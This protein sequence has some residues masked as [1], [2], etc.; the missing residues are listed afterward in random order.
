MLV[1]GVDLPG[2]SAR[3]RRCGRRAA[4]LLLPRVR[5]G[6]G[7]RRRGG[8]DRG[9]RQGTDLVAARP[10]RARRRDRA[11]RPLRQVL[12]ATLLDRHRRDPVPRDRLGDHRQRRAGPVDRQHPLLL[13]GR[14]RPPLQLRAALAAAVHLPAGRRRTAAT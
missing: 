5:P 11:R 13:P 2:R 1:A 6:H 4:D 10:L 3:G 8:P 9:G 12:A 7:G 14:P